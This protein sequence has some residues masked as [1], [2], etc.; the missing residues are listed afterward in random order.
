MLAH[1]HPISNTQGGGLSLYTVCISKVPD[2][3]AKVRF[4]SICRHDLDPH[5]CVHFAG[6]F[7]PG[8]MHT[9]V[10]V[11][12]MPTNAEEMELAHPHRGP[13]K[14]ALISGGWVLAHP[15]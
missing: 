8:K 10:G 12:A 3:M 2:G 11:Q 4:L 1:H 14:H 7:G 9:E 5:P 6:P 15:P 13:W